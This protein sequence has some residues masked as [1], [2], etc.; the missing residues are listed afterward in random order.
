[1][2]LPPRRGRSASGLS[3]RAASKGCG[4]FVLCCLCRIAPVAWCPAGVE[5]GLRAGTDGGFGDGHEGSFTTVGKSF[6]KSFDIQALREYGGLSGA[7]G[8][9]YWTQLGFERG[10][11]IYAETF[12]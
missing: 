9:A 12:F 8:I 3:A 10:D 1:M 7:E 2:L 5:T 6:D 11:A 4:L